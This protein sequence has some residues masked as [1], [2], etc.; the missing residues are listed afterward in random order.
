MA[1]KGHGLY[2]HSRD[3]YMLPVFCYIFYVLPHSDL[4]L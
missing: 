2:N 3:P 4:Y 1:V